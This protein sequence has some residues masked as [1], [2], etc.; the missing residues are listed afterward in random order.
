MEPCLIFNSRSSNTIEPDFN[1]LHDRA[2]ERN[3]LVQGMGEIVSM[4][5]MHHQTNSGYGR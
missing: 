3:D 2:G 5:G 1:F 4:F